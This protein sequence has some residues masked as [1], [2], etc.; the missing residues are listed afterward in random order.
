[1]VIRFRKQTLIRLIL[2]ISMSLF[3]LASMTPAAS[4]QGPRARRVCA[5]SDSV[6]PA[7][8]LREHDEIWLVS[9]RHLNHADCAV[10]QLRCSRFDGLQWQQESAANL[11]T[12]HRAAAEK[13]TV[14]Y[15]HGNRTDLNWAK[16]RGLGV[17]RSLFA[18]ADGHRRR[19]ANRVGLANDHDCRFIREYKQNL[20]RSRLHGRIVG[21]LLGELR[22]SSDSIG[23]IGYSMGDPGSGKCPGN[24]P[25]EPQNEAALMQIALIAPVFHYDWPCQPSSLDVVASQIDNLTVVNNSPIER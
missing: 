11:L 16:S 17:Y 20:D 2:C 23:L 8:V 6:E 24:V 21:S 15:I 12:E 1:M 22:K 25:A 5:T 19:A 14:I 7:T 10:D 13:R 9:S 3:C 18:D 4:A